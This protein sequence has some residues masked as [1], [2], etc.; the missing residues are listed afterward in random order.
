MVNLAQLLP[1]DLQGI[2]EQGSQKHSPRSLLIVVPHRDGT[3]SSTF[4]E[5]METLGHGDIFKIDP[6]EGRLQEFDC[7]ND[8]RRIFG[9][10]ADWYRIHAAQILEEQRLA[11][12][13]RQSCFRADVTQAKDSGAVRDDRNG[14]R[15]IGVLEDQFRLTL[16][17]AAGGCDSRCV[18]DRELP[19]L[20]NLTFGRR[21]DFA[22]VIGVEPKRLF[23]RLLGFR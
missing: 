19:H 15:L 16:N 2:V 9:S 12:H 10:K 3:G 14:I 17:C 22:L 7:P 5:D 18:P 13:D 23:C 21:L 8:L 1:D 6:A 20:R 11:F 4:M